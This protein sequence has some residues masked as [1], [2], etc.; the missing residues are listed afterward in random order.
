MVYRE[1]IWRLCSTAAG[2]LWTGPSP[3]RHRPGKWICSPVSPQLPLRAR[4]IIICFFSFSFSPSLSVHPLTDFKR[5]KGT[6]NSIVC[7]LRYDCIFIYFFSKCTFTFSIWWWWWNNAGCAIVRFDAYCFSVPTVQWLHRAWKWAH[8]LW[9]EV[10]ECVCVCVCPCM[11]SI[12]FLSV[13]W[14]LQTVS[15]RSAELWAGI[16]C[17]LAK[18]EPWNHFSLSLHHTCEDQH[19]NKLLRFILFR[20]IFFVSVTSN[21]Q[22]LIRGLYCIYITINNIGEKTIE[23][24]FPLNAWKII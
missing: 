17:L 24:L 15:F 7:L 4:R 10:C 12:L 1:N 11:C 19:T 18:S 14:M 20:P 2:L 23:V 6:C 5:L 16:S 8:K 21:R 9:S 13:L 22:H 3:I